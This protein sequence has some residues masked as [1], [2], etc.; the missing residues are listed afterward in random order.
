MKKRKI[1]WNYLNLKL[2]LFSLNL[3]KISFYFEILF[4]KKEM[5][6]FIK[7]ELA[8]SKQGLKINGV[9]Y[10]ANIQFDNNEI[11]VCDETKENADWL[12]DLFNNAQDLKKYIVVYQAKKYELLPESLL[13]LIIFKIKN[14]LSGIINEIEINI[15]EDSDQEII[16]RIKSSL[17]VI[18]IP[19]SFT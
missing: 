17:L 5:T 2:F 14:Q 7:L 11:I 12:N 8:I 13:T 10:K 19:N 6:E 4:V 9:D 16:Q 18:N 15:P 1:V 3:S